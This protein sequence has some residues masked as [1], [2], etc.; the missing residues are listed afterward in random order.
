MEDGLMLRKVGPR[1]GKD[2]VTEAPHSSREP[3][4]VV[5]D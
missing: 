2:A 5:V 1:A 3:G 4:G